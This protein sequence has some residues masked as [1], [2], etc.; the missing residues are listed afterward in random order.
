[1][2][3]LTE[4][5][6]VA[7]ETLGCRLNQADSEEL[8]RRFLHEG[9]RVIN[10][11]ERADVV[12]VNSCTVTHIADRQS[13][14]AVR[15]AARTNPNAVVVLT[16][17]Y[18]SVAPVEAA[19]VVGATLVLSNREKSG[20]IH[21]V[22]ELLRGRGQVLAPAIDDLPAP[23]PGWLGRTRVQLKVE[24]GCNNRCS[25]CIVPSARGRQVS[26]P[27]GECIR[28]VH[29]FVAEGYK[30]VVLTG[31]HLGGYGRDLTLQRPEG[32]NRPASLA[33][34]IGAILEQTGIARLRLSSVEPQD[35]P[36]SHLDLWQDRRLCRHFHLPAQSGSNPVL[37]RMRRGYTRERYQALTEAIRAFV[38]GAA[39]T[40][41]LIVGFPGETDGDFA[42]TCQFVDEVSFAKVHLF[43]YSVRE[44]TEAATLTDQVAPREAR[45]RL[46]RLA[47]LAD[48]HARR[49]HDAQ[50]GATMDV[51]WEEE[52]QPGVWQGLTDNYL[53]VQMCHHLP[54]HN[55]MTAVTLTDTTDFGFAVRAVAEAGEPLAPRVSE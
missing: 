31:T 30:E 21:R 37:R 13:R 16:G 45:R 29:Q 52:V 20:L 22:S 11:L 17:C 49:F 33:D 51:L 39:I 26:R 19:R 24:E 40:T 2:D 15:C 3:Q 4:H 10:D 6:S 34:L 54:L 42:A 27:I 25:F 47:Q 53:R 55:Q 18:P 8:A 9:Y 5:P 28:M 43:P 48:Y 36:V 35:F 50:R 44:G 23:L 41:D 1:M 32:G 12:I 14:Q 7:I 38:P 46:V